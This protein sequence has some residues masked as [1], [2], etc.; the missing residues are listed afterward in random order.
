MII[1][2]NEQQNQII[3]KEYNITTLKQLLI[4]L[5]NEKDKN[6][7]IRIIHEIDNHLSEMNPTQC[8]IGY[9]K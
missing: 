1:E 7:V 4:R 2:K 8:T 5:E 6:Q 9:Q 3:M